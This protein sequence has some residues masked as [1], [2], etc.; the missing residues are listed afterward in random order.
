MRTGLPAVLLLLAFPLGTRLPAQAAPGPLARLGPQGVYRGVEDGA[1]GT[2]TGTT[3]W[4]SLY[5]GRWVR[6]RYR[7][8]LSGQI[9]VDG[10]LMLRSYPDGEVRGWHLDDHGTARRWRGRVSERGMV[11]RQFDPEG[12]LLAMQVYQWDDFGYEFQLLTRNDAGELVAFQQGSFRPLRGDPLLDPPEA[13]LEAARELPFSRY[14]GSFAGTERSPFGETEAR[15]HCVPVLGGGWFETTYTS[16]LGDERSYAGVGYTRCLPDGSTLLLWFDDR[17][18]FARLEG[19]VTA[20]GAEAVRRDED[21]TVV[22]R[23]V[24]RVTPEGYDYRIEVRED[25]GDAWLPY[26][27]ASYRRVGD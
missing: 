20:A 11:L 13:V 9:L 16:W 27:E 22:E 8:M 23:H 19:R 2:S 15:F 14:T 5:E 12:R 21:G 26:L 7:S 6:V 17:G 18:D 4:E 24:D 1:Y 25:G 10:I 3:R